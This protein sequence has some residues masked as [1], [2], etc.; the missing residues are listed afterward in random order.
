VLQCSDLQCINLSAIL[1]AAA[2]TL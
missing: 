2:A 1:A